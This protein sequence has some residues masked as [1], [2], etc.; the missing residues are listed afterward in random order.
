MTGGAFSI[1]AA[2]R[3][4]PARA[5]LVYQDGTVTSYGALA[6][7]VARAV[8]WLRASGAVDDP[9]RPVAFVAPLGPRAI[10]LA[11]A[12]LELGV[13]M[14]PLH[15]RAGAAEHDAQRALAD[16]TLVDLEPDARAAPWATTPP[17]SIAEPPPDDAR[18]LALL[19]TSGTTGRPRAVE[20]SR[21]AFATAA[22]A[23][24]AR[25]GWRSPPTEDRWLLTLPLAHVGGLSVLLRCLAARRTIVLHDARFDA[26]AAHAHLAAAGVTIASFVPTQLARLVA[27]DLPSPPRLRVALVGGA[28]AAPALLHDAARLGWPALPT[29]GLTEAAAQVATRAPGTPPTDDAG[30]GFPLDGIIVTLLPDEAAP[31]GAGR[32]ALAGPTLLTRFL[33][34]SPARDAAGRYVTSDLGLLDER[35]RL[36]V[37]GRADDVVI[38][39]GEKVMPLEVE[40][41]L[42]AHPAVARAVVFGLPDREWGTILAAAVEPRAAPADLSPA[43]AALAPWKRPRRTAWLA[44]PDTPS[45][46]LDR[47]AAIAA[48]TTQLTRTPARG[49]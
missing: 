23:S 9:A 28:A 40:A 41:A 27:A 21:A 17:A 18:P 12:L 4:A 36:H 47:R 14:L 42:T 6:D 43:L 20:L 2:A 10:A 8:G 45:G 33:D 29:Y 34:G 44:L 16:A 46:K 22:R 25:L 11:C 5:F 39:G 49:E 48:A 37:L 15:A 38:T 35:G 3:E 1:T 31:A 32:I 19:F 30:C 24:A 13:P 26:R 7:E